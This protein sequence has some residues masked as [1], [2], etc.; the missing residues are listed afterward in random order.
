MSKEEALRLL[1]TDINDPGAEKSGEYLEEHV[2]TRSERLLKAN[3]REG[4]LNALR[5]WLLSRSEPRTMLAIT[6]ARK[7]LLSELKSEIA[8][9]RSEIA[10]GNLFLPFY[11]KEVDEALKALS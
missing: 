3:N 9:I 10:N 8:I 4:L 5:D 7:F 2:I 1:E 6:V 11:L